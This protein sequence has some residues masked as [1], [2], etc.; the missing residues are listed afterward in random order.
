MLPEL[1]AKGAPMTFTYKDDKGVTTERT[2]TPYGWAKQGVLMFHGY[3]HL[4]E[5]RR[6][7]RADRVVN[8]EAVAA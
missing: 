7:F 1:V 4:R 2:I 3:C 6:S 5:E 8:V